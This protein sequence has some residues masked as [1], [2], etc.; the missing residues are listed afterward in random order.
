[1]TSTPNWGGNCFVSFSLQNKRTGTLSGSRFNKIIKNLIFDI[2]N[3]GNINRLKF[4]TVK[5]IH[6]GYL[7]IRFP[8]SPYILHYQ[9]PT[10]LII[11]FIQDILKPR[12][13]RNTTANNRVVSWNSET[14]E[15]YM[16]LK[17]PT[18]LIICFIQDILK[19][20]THRN[21]AAN[22]R[23]VSWNSETAWN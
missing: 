7:R 20:R 9:H 16:V 11:C 23:V 6:R 12:T 2:H 8:L 18:S 21:T 17:H 10:S 5:L 4:F 15:I 1:M 14:A 22:N 19:P 13:H 3:D